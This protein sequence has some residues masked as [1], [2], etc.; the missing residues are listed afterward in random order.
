[1]GE[2]SRHASHRVLGGWC[3]FCPDGRSGNVLCH[4]LGLPWGM[5]TQGTCGPLVGMQAK[6]EICAE[7]LF[8][9]LFVFP[10]MGKTE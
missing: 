3:W 5:S 4:W 2:K 1:M 6:G 8:V 7:F 9:C 10:L